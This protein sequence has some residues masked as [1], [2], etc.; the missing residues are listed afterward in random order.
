MTN[1]ESDLC[2]FPDFYRR[3]VEGDHGDD[4][5]NEPGCR[6]RGSFTRAA[7]GSLTLMVVLQNPGEPL[8]PEEMELESAPDTDTLAARLWA[9]SGRVWDEAAGSRTLSIARREISSLLDVPE[10]DCSAHA[11]FTNVVRC[12]GR[13]PGAATIA[14]GVAWLLEEIALWSPRLVLAYGD[15]P[16][17]ALRRHGIH[18]DLHLPHPA[19]RGDWLRPG[20]RESSLAQVRS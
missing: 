15:V 10:A 8:H 6:P 12:T 13:N 7:P 14:R 3:I 1:F 9:F 17:R 5:R 19:A 11:M 18:F 20:R 2:P 16:C 4:V